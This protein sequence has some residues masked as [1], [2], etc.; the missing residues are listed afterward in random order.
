[1]VDHQRNFP[2][3]RFRLR[4]QTAT[5]VVG[6]TNATAAHLLSK[7]SILLLQV[8]DRVLLFPVEPASE[9]HEKEL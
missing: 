3:Q 2:S 8:F 4:G 7:N 1:M 5:L 9:R 6:K